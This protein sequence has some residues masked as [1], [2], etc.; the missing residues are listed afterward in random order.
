MQVSF[1]A[2][3]RDFPSSKLGELANDSERF[4]ACELPRAGVS[5]ARATVQT[6]LIALQ[7][8]LPDDI[9]GMEDLPSR[10]VPNGAAS[11]FS[12]H[13][14]RHRPIHHFHRREELEEAHTGARA[15][16]R[17]T[18]HLTRALHRVPISSAARPTSCNGNG[19]NR[20]DWQAEALH[21]RGNPQVGS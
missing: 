21:R 5:C 7:R 4:V 11:L 19:D 12:R 17:T 13:P 9:P 1:S 8:E 16:A 15:A 18:M 6:P 10:G 2:N 14:F 20:L 3:E